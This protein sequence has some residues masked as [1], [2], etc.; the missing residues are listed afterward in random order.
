MFYTFHTNYKI[1]FCILFLLF[2]KHFLQLRNVP[3]VKKEK[4]RDK[5]IFF[6]KNIQFSF[7]YKNNKS[8]EY[9]QN[10]ADDDSSSKNKLAVK[11]IWK[12]VNVTCSVVC[13][14]TKWKV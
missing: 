11:L 3:I 7:N 8:T 10:I 9:K 5:N 1:V 6:R 2:L 12:M 13:D 14:Q 4:F